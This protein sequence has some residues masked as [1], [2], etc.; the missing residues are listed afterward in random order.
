MAAYGAELISVSQEDGGMEGARDLALARLKRALS[1][2]IVD[3]VQ[4]TT[5]LFH[6]LLEQPDIQAGRYN[7]HWLEKFLANGGMD[8]SGAG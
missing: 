4:T 8:Q 6:E 2:L 5:P 7:I 3:G 1:E